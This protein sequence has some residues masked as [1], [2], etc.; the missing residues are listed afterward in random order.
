MYDVSLEGS[1]RIARRAT[2]RAFEVR[3]YKTEVSKSFRNRGAGYRFA[4]EK[5]RCIYYV[6]DVIIVTNFILI[7]RD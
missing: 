2:C 3:K 7:L 6:I 4:K 5:S 1:A